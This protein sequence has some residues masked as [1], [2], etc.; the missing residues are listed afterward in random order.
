MYTL[1]QRGFERS[2]LGEGMTEDTATASS[3]Y[4]FRSPM[5]AHYKRLIDQAHGEKLINAKLSLYG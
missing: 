1:P 2:W 3:V 5:D 4:N